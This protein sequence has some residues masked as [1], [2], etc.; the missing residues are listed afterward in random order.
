RWCGSE[1]RFLGREPNH[2]LERIEFE[3]H[4][5]CSF[6]AGIAGDDGNTRLRFPVFS[7]GH[8]K[9]DEHQPVCPSALSPDADHRADGAPAAVAVHGRDAA[10]R[11]DP[12]VDRGPDP[13]DRTLHRRMLSQL[14]MIVSDYTALAQ[15]GRLFS[16]GGLAET[17]RLAGLLFVI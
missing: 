1:R 14:R 17:V 13:G 3:L 5:A 10:L 2:E 8:S 11:S 15:T 4:F 7:A 16:S 12:V 6:L 9:M